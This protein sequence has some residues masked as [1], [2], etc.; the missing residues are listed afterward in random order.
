MK[1]T[2]GELKSLGFD[3]TNWQ[4]PDDWD[5]DGP[6]VLVD[7]IPVGGE[8]DFQAYNIVF[9]PGPDLPDFADHELWIFEYHWSGLAC[10]GTFDEWG[11][12]HK[13]SCYPAVEKTVTTYV[14]AS[15]L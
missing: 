6:K 14:V 10:I 15:N 2:I 8:D 1:I 7:C 9:R 3:A 13:L 4:D 12:S 11:D 5:P